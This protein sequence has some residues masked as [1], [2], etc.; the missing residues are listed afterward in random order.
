MDQDDTGALIRH[1]LT[2]AGGSL[3]TNGLFTSAQWQDVVGGLMTIGAVAWS[4][5]QKRQAKAK[6]NAAIAAPAGKAQ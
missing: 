6:L 1:I 4:L 3:V 2:A 5:W